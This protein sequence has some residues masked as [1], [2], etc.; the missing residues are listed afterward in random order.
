M[1][2]VI[3]KLIISQLN[4][5]LFG[6]SYLRWT[7]RRWGVRRTRLVWMD[8]GQA[9]CTWCRFAPGRLPVSANTAAKCASKPSQ[10]VWT[11]TPTPACVCVWVVCVC[12]RRHSLDQ[13]DLISR[14]DLFR[15]VE[16]NASLFHF[17]A[18]RFQVWQVMRVCVC[19]CLFDCFPDKLLS[20]MIFHQDHVWLSQNA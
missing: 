1:E 6:R 20:S 10:M 13:S 9:P 4:V 15:V 3:K 5:S 14:A 2:S 19:V 8:Y 18:P 11:P 12:V 17:Y 16:I 7:P